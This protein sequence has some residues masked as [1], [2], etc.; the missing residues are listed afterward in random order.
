MARSGDDHCPLCESWERRATSDSRKR[1]SQRSS[2]QGSGRDGYGRTS[3]TCLAGGRKWHRLKVYRAST[4]SQRETRVSAPIS[5][6]FMH[7]LNRGSTYSSTCQCPSLPF[8]LPPIA[9]TSPGP[10]SSSSHGLQYVSGLAY[11]RPQ[12]TPFAKSASHSDFIHC[13]ISNST[14]AIS[15]ISN[16]ASSARMLSSP[17][18]RLSES[19]KRSSLVPQTHQNDMSFPLATETL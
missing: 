3:A 9:C 4:R 1:C 16:G 11:M 14:P 10:T 2:N 17:H 8:S 19:T 13:S 12:M 5:G 15:S 6:A 18:S 7:N